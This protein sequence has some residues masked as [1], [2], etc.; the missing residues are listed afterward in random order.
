MPD[1]M[2]LVWENQR[3]LELAEN[4]EERRFLK[5]KLAER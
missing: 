5:R 2:I 1:F 3:A 4:E